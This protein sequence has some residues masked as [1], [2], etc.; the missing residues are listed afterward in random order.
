MLA[1][2]PEP[3]PPLETQLRTLK[4]AL[5]PALFGDIV[6]SRV[7]CGELLCSDEDKLLRQ[8]ARQVI[9]WSIFGNQ[10][11]VLAREFLIADRRFDAEHVVGIAFGGD[12][13]TRLHEGE[14][15]VRETEALRD[16]PKELFF[17]GVQYFVGLSDVEETSE[18][19]M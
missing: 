4:F 17:L 15:G 11:A 13:V 16:L 19:R 3:L 18:S 6:V 2:E 12:S 14:L 7:D 1:K 9:I 5:N 8:A 10:S